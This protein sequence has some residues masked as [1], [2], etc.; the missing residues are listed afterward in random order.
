MARTVSLLFGLLAV[1]CS[2]SAPADSG[3]MGDP[4]DGSASAVCSGPNTPDVADMS[5]GCDLLVGS[6]PCTFCPQGLDAGAGPYTVY[7]GE[8]TCP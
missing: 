6:A 3:S 8:C 5:F 2:S 7:P 1:A 4:R